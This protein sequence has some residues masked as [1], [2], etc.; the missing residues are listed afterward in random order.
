MRPRSTSL[1]SDTW[2][3]PHETEQERHP[4]R[5]QGMSKENFMTLFAELSEKADLVTVDMD[6]N[7]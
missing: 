7:S 1:A 3:N 2:R 4:Q 5:Q 6:S